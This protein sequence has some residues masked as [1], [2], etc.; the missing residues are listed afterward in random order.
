MGAIGVD[1]GGIGLGGS[2]LGTGAF[3]KRGKVNLDLEGEEAD[4]IGTIDRDAVR[5]VIKNNIRSFRHCYSR[6][7]RSKSKLFGRVSLEWY[8]VER[9]KAKNV[10][11]HKTTMKNKRMMNCL[12][13]K[14]A[15]LQFPE[16]PPN[17]KVK[18]IYPF[19][20]SSR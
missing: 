16:P 3:G 13:K 8:I 15:G 20:F 19:V 11:V 10:K 4:F 5:R 17:T 6:E 1:T 7:L 12:K 2:G 9:G 14:M 18:V